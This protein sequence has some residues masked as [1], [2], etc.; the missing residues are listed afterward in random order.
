MDAPETR[1]IDGRQ[2]VLDIV[3]RRYVAL[4]PEEWGRQQVIHHLHFQLGY[5]LELMYVEGQIELNGLTR[6]CDIVVY[7][8]Q[9]RPVMIV[10]CKQP[11]IP[12]T[13]QVADQACRYNIALQVP[14]I[15]L[16]NGRQHWMGRVIADER[17]MEPL[18]ELPSWKTLNVFDKPNTDELARMLRRE[19][20]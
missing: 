20:A 14:Y 15:Y 9:M 19:N 16:T 10:E 3:R 12:L 13:Q 5:P 8:L 4:T 6:R 17:R 2:E 18:E 11:Q 7:N 1:I